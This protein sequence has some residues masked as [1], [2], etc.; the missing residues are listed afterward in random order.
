MKQEAERFTLVALILQP[1]DRFIG[2]DICRIALRGR[3]FAIGD[4]RSV[5][6][7]TLAD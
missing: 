1:F 5:V 7:D 6:I 4:K 3:L 2:N